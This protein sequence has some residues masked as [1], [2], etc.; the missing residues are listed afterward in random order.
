[1]AQSVFVV[2]Q[3]TDLVPL[4]PIVSGRYRDRFERHAGT[5]RFAERVIDTELVGDVSDHLSDP[6]IRMLTERRS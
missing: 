4:Q 6:I 3:A 2:F 5:W 1:M